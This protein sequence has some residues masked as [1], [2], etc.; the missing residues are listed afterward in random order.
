MIRAV[1]FDLW[2]TL[3]YD[4]PQISEQR[5]ELRLRSVSTVLSAFGC[6]YA[7]D[8]IQAA[9]LAAGTEL[10]RIHGTERDISPRGRTVLYLR[11][12][13]PSLAERLDDDAWRHLDE[14]ILAPA[15]THRPPML[16]GAVDVLAAIKA[17]GLRV[18]LISN[19]GTTPG[20]VLT[21]LLAEMGM[22]QYFDIT[23]FSDEV[24]LSK[25]APAIFAHALEQL[26][27][28]P[29]EVVFVGDH[30]VLDVLGAR[31][32]GMWMVQIGDLEPDGAEPH[33]R[34]DA[35][36]ELLPALR[37]LALID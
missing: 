5:D 34:I 13:D 12:L 6:A 21:R 36:G 17:L 9:F 3:I 14:A 8:D 4:D 33:A 1:V 25:P 29:E 35:L 19:A 7:P 20:I 24:E 18:G 22:H 26:D 28:P 2:G 37:S 32:A 23:V 27:L 31:R 15:L 16:P 10:Q 11:H 30:P